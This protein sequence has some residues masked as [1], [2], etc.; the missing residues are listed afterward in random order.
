MGLAAELHALDAGRLGGHPLG[1]RLG[2]GALAQVEVLGLE[3][4]AANGFGVGVLGQL[5]EA[6][7]VFAGLGQGHDVEVLADQHGVAVP[8]H[9]QLADLLEDAVHGDVDAHHAFEEITAIDR[10]DGRGH[11]A[12]TGRVE[13][14]IGPHHLALRVVLGIGEV[15]EVVVGD[16]HVMGVLVRGEE[17]GVDMVEAVPAVEVQRRHQRGVGLDLLHQRVEASQ[18]GHLVQVMLGRRRAVGVEHRRPALVARAVAHAVGAQGQVVH[19]ARRRLLQGLGREVAV[20]LGH[21]ADLGQL[22]LHH[23]A[24]EGGRG[25]QLGH[26]AVA[27]VVDL[28]FTNRTVAQQIDGDQHRFHQ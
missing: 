12:L 4:L 28:G 9:L 18:A 7:I 6:E 1:Q 22:L 15:I 5:V 27:Q 20:Q 24:F 16:H 8:R 2:F 10:G 23:P 26:R 21:P 11:P 19:R 13:V 3:Q 17:P 14:D 25:L